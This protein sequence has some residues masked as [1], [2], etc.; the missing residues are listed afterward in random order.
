[1]PRNEEKV[2]I[3]DDDRDVLVAARLFL[4]QHFPIVRTEHDPERLPSLLAEDRFDVILLDMNFTK[5]VTSGRE[6]FFW[7]EKI[8]K[9]DPQAIVVFITAYADVDLAVRAVKA[10]ATDFVE[11]PW[12]NEKLL[13]TVSSALELGTSRKEAATFRSRQQRL[14]EDLDQPYHDFV[15]QSA[16][17]RQVYDMI[18]KVAPTDVHVLITGENGTGKELVARAIHRQSERRDEVFVR[19]D[20]GA[21]AETLFESE[22]FGHVKGAFTDAREDR[23]GRF[24]IASAGS[25]FLDEIGNLPLTLQPK[26]LSVLQ[27]GQVT[28]VGSN[29]V[30]T[31][32]VRP[33]CAT[34]LSL[35]ELVQK[36]RF[37]QDLL[38][39]INTVEIHV[40]ALR[41]R[42][43]DIPML[44]DHFL[45]IYGAKYRKT[46]IKAGHTALKKLQHYTWP[47]NVRELQHAV[48][49][50]IIMSSSRV[51]KPEDFVL[52]S[53]DIP[54]EGFALESYNLEDV[55]KAVIK[56]VLDRHGGNVSR[57][58]QEL[59]LTRTS[60]Y[61]R[62]QRYGV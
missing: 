36:G 23:A 53:G 21:L 24:E 28:R 22:L 33:I 1:M 25:L 59:G 32:D 29:R 45:R 56:R 13:A 19:V 11:K 51:L 40:P 5:D 38:Y 27:T 4:K 47:G 26:L 39:R 43:E 3:V 6:G 60:L 52:S 49:R 50:A 17:M 7:L 55:E 9:L 31:V 16:A 14:S 46:G 35:Q 44:V 48:E 12:K 41:D 20:L 30:R 8:L 61:R 2:L 58:A 10:G 54:G 15:G 37:R 57:S 18:E 62:M 34:N 42:V